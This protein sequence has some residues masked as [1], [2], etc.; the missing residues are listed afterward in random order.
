MYS[1][2]NVLIFP[3]GTEI[4]LE[5]NNALKFNKMIR[6]IGATSSEDHSRMVYKE[7]ISGLPFVTDDDFIERINEVCEKNKIDFIYP[8]HDSVCLKLAQHLDELSA[9]VVTSPLE[10]VE[11]CRSKSKTYEHFAGEDFIPKTYEDKSEID[12]YPVFVKP[13]VGQGSNGAVKVNNEKE[14]DMRL[15]SGDDVVICEYLDGMEYTVDCFTDIHGE[16]KVASLRNRKRMRSGISAN[17]EILT[18][19]AR[20]LD[21][22]NR[23]NAKLEFNGAWFFQLKRNNKGE[24]KLLE[25]SPRIPGTMGLSR[26]RGVNFQILSIYNMLG[27]DVGI[28]QHDYNIEVDRALIS[29]YKIRQSYSTVYVD[30]DDTLIFE[31]KVNQWLMMFLYQCVNKHIKLILITRHDGDIYSRLANHKISADLF[32]E[33]LHLD[34]EADK[35]EFVKEKDAIFIDDSFRERK[36]VMD[37]CGINVFDVDE[38]EALIDWTDMSW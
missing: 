2:Y 15:Y 24:Y 31:E 32:E 28:L 18:P 35:S 8:A 3:A 12:S 33:I 14:L 36:D 21:I 27:Y 20:L 34:R 1:I 5:I 30:F 25:I 29:R 9:K 13:S 23:I 38:V 7:V 4:G 19:D 6:V 17:S 37:K 16:L 22:A 10:T 11:I 26:N